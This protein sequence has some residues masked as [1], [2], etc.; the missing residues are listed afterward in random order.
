MMPD[1]THYLRFAK[2]GEDLL[3]DLLLGSWEPCFE[4]RLGRQ[5]KSDGALHKHRRRSCLGSGQAQVTMMCCL[6]RLMQASTPGV[7]AV[8]SKVLRCYS[9]CT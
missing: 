8:A 4:L 1:I 3:K 9:L 2:S 6:T 5:H 7:L